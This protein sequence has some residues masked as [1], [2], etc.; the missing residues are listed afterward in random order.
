MQIPLRT[1]STI[2]DYVATQEWQRARLSCCPLHP[3]GGCAF[4]RHGSYARLTSPGVRIARCYCPQGRTTFSLLP[5]FLAARL[6]GSLAAIDRIVGIAASARSMEAAAD[7][8]RGPDIC[9]PGAVRW[10]RRRVV[11]VRRSV[12]AVNVMAPR[13]SRPSLSVSDVP[14]LAT[15]RRALSPQLLH[16]IPAPLGFQPFRRIDIRD[17]VGGSAPDAI[18]HKDSGMPLSGDRWQHDAGRDYASIDSYAVPIEVKRCSRISIISL[19][20]IPPRPPP[21]ISV[22]SGVRSDGLG[23]VQR[24]FI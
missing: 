21:T 11:A 13:L 4:R 12:A 2:E 10:L 15:L 16:S 20:P 1:K 5:D 23:P 22:A 6:P 9:L 18:G 7:A 24:L 17:D 8:A 19:Q 14:P 3:N